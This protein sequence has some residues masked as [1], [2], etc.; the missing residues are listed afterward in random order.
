[1][2][3]T[4]LAAGTKKGAAFGDLSMLKGAP[5]QLTLQ[6]N[7]RQREAFLLRSHKNKLL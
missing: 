4:Y 2:L 6:H 5:C 3:T 7:K 1:M